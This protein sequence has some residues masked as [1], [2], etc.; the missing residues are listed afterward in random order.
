MNYL[1]KYNKY[2]NKLIN[3][4]N[5]FRGGNPP[6]KR[7]KKE[8]EKL[9]K[10]GYKDIEFDEG[11]LNLKFK[12]ID[13]INY[14]VTFPIEYP[15]KPPTIN[16]KILLA[17]SW[18]P[19][20][21]IFEEISSKKVLI[22]CHTQCVTGSFEPLI[23][24]K[25]W[26]GSFP[27]PEDSLFKKL[28]TKFSLTGQSIFETVDLGSIGSSG[29]YT[30]NAFSD[31]FIDAHIQEYDIVMVPDCSGIWYTSQLDF[32]ENKAGVKIKDLS[33]DEQNENKTN[34]IRSCLNLSKM[35]K[36][37]GI[38]LFGKFIGED[39]N[40]YFDKPDINLECN[41]NGKMYDSFS[42]ALNFNLNEQGF[43]SEKV[44]IEIVDGHVQEFVFVIAQKK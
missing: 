9:F 2:N 5:K 18:S 43:A 12:S 6:I 30:A 35:L 37:R 38:L 14:E 28:F 29:T 40:I 16:G 26:Y 21:T 8:I 32:I 1:N 24:N 33:I 22:F 31:E 41:I 34:L 17:A 39:N 4:N 13:N 10:N 25:H 20:R 36:P 27:S 42:S 19:A 7:I 3:F 23:L 44:K 15:I 11:K